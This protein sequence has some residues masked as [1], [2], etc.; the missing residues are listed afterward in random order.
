MDRLFKVLKGS[1]ASTN[2]SHQI[3]PLPKDG[4][5]GAW[6]RPIRGPLT[7]SNGYHLW[8]GEDLLVS[9]GPVIYEADS[10][11]DRLE[12]ERGIVVREA[13]LARRLEQWNDEAARD[14]AADCA[15]H[16]LPIFEQQRPRDSRPRR[17]V[18]MARL[19]SRGSVTAEELA[20]AWSAARDVMTADLLTTGGDA[21]AAATAAAMTAAVGSGWSPTSF[22]GDVAHAARKAAAWAATRKVA[23]D[24]WGT[25]DHVERS[26]LRESMAETWARAE[27]RELAWQSQQLLAHVVGGQVQHRLSTARTAA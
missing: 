21:L 27:A 5:P 9:L 18:E 22:A 17:A 6:M 12:T 24:H 15:E 25:T 4:Q 20:S 7:E 16:V 2:D 1:G 8:R 11:G 13:R 10:R 23:E 14:F 19:F 3:W 26:M